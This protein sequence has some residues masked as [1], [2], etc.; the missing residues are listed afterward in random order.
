MYFSKIFKIK[1]GKLEKFKSWLHS[2]ETDRR[3]EALKTFEYENI[4][5]EVF[6]IFKGKD[7]NHYVIGLNEISDGEPKAGDPNVKINQEHG[8]IKKE[9]LE[10]FSD[11]GEVILDLR[12]Q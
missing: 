7:S 12:R 11:N 1:E 3:E 6:A 9:C 2:L 10:P 4:T 5:R 8:V